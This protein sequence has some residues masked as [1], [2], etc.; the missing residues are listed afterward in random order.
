MF[1]QTIAH[2]ATMDHTHG[3]NPTKP[4]H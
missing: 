3:N 1:S 4:S 2:G